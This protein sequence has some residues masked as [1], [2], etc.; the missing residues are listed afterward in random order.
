[1]SFF[2][3]ALVGLGFCSALAVE[4]AASDL[5]LTGLAATG[6]RVR[7]FFS[8][9]TAS[10]GGAFSVSLHQESLG[11]RLVSVNLRERT[12]LISEGGIERRLCLGG[13]TAAGDPVDAESAKAGRPNTGLRFNSSR[14]PAGNPSVE[15]SAPS[16][17]GTS[18]EGSTGLDGVR[19]ESNIPE[20]ALSRDGIAAPGGVSDL[21]LNPGDTGA[22]RWVPGV[23]RDPTEA[24]VFRAKYGTTAMEERSRQE[25]YAAGLR[26]TP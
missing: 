15:N 6:G 19:I 23:V 9:P 21:G 8:S 11:V 10:G 17:V 1:V 16:S 2:R 22:H 20:R 4:A 7:A 3:K 24:E 12:A 26:R 25:R 5:V 13:G 14:R 18:F